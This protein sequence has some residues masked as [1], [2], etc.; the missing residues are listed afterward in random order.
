MGPVIRGNQINQLAPFHCQ[1]FGPAP[2]TRAGPAKSGSRDA[3]SCSAHHADRANCP[4]QDE[5]ATHVSVGVDCPPIPYLFLLFLTLRIFP[6]KVPG[7]RFAPVSPVLRKEN[8]LIGGI[9]PLL[10]SS[11]LFLFFSTLDFLPIMRY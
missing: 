4:G 11:F 1:R 7:T 8:F 10:F 2:G 5:T 9:G 6:R 3:P